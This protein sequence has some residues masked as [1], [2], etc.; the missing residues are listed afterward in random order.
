MIM[1]IHERT[2]EIGVLRSLGWTAFM[3]LKEVLAEGLALT[4]LSGVLAI[5][6]TL[7]LVRVLRALP[8]LGFYRDMFIV[9]PEL[10]LQGLTLCV[11]LGIVG[12]LYPAWRATRLRPV[13]ALRYE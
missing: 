6:T 7:L 1:S 9:T 11:A 8:N 13:E 4:L 12:G 5:G 2:R 3:V 10:V